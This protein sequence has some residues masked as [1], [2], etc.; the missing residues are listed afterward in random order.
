MLSEQLVQELRKLNRA[1]K[2]RAVQLGSV[3]VSFR[4]HPKSLSLRERD[5]KNGRKLFFS[6]SP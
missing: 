6:P 4:P 5:F 2:L 1:E 3:D